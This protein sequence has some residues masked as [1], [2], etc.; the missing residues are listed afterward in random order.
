MV[1]TRGIKIPTGPSRF[2]PTLLWAVGMKTAPKVRHGCRS[3]PGFEP[4]TLRTKRAHSTLS[5]T[6]PHILLCLKFQVIWIPSLIA[7]IKYLILIRIKFA[8]YFSQFPSQKNGQ[9]SLSNWALVWS[10]A[11]AEQDLLEAQSGL[12]INVELNLSGLT[13]S[14]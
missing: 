14:D 4:R 7:L 1:S 10:R 12:D 5:A 11:I 13:S 8:V 6:E 9:L 3:S 2:I